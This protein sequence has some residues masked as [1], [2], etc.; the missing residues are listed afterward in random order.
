MNLL[1]LRSIYRASRFPDWSAPSTCVPRTLSC[2]PSVMLRIPGDLGLFFFGWYVLFQ[3]QYLDVD[4]REMH[5]LAPSVHP[6]SVLKGCQIEA[7]RVSFP[8]HAPIP[9]PGCLVCCFSDIAAPIAFKLVIQLR[10]HGVLVKWSHRVLSRRRPVC[11]FPDTHRA[12]R[13]LQVGDSNVDFV[14]RNVGTRCACDP[15]PS[16]GGFCVWNHDLSEYVAW[17]SCV[18]RPNCCF[19]DRHC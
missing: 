17:R 5:F 15:R 4:H 3:R 7:S 2:T 12:Q 14:E 13:A 16:I 8:R 19:H 10:S 9:F 18:K 6:P 11:H 1:L